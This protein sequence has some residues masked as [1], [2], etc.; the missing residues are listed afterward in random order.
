MVAEATDWEM[1]AFT[2]TRGSSIAYITTACTGPGWAVAFLNSVAIW[3]RELWDAAGVTRD[4]GTSH[5]FR[6]TFATTLLR[7]GEDLATLRDLL[8]HSDISVT[9]RYLAATPQRHK[10][11]A[12]LATLPGPLDAD[13]KLTAVLEAVPKPCG[14]RPGSPMFRRPDISCPACRPHARMPETKQ[15]GC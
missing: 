3:L 15:D 12:A 14:D 6:H 9:S 11:V 7:A 10:A 5:R 2:T 8:G 1:R 13:L 4:H